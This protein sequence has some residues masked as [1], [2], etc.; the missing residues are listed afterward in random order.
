MNVKEGAGRTVAVHTKI[1]CRTFN[2]QQSTHVYFFSFIFL[3]VFFVPSF[4]V[5]D[6]HRTLYLSQCLL[7]GGHRVGGSGS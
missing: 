5:V 4:E 2:V 3:L 6:L 7:C 1:D